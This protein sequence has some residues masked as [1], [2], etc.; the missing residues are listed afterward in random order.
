M[1]KIDYK[2]L[3]SPTQFKEYRKITRDFA[4]NLRRWRRLIKFTTSTQVLENLVVSNSHDGKVITR[5]FDDV[6]GSGSLPLKQMWIEHKEHKIMSNSLRH[7]P[8]AEYEAELQCNAYPS[9]KSRDYSR[10]NSGISPRSTMSDNDYSV[11]RWCTECLTPTIV[12]KESIYLCVQCN[13]SWGNP[14]SNKP[15]PKIDN[16]GGDAFATAC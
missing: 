7:I 10:N 4:H 15:K 1:N 16:I 6:S 3:L 14:I 11:Q 13:K 9:E 8:I 2:S 12:K 5:D